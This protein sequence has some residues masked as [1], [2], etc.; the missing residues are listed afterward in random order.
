MFCRQANS[1]AGRGKKKEEVNPYE[2]EMP[3]EYAKQETAGDFEG[4]FATTVQ[5]GESVPLDPLVLIRECDPL[6][7]ITLK[8]H[9]TTGKAHHLCKIEDACDLLPFI[10]TLLKVK[11]FIT[12]SHDKYKKMMASALWK[13]GLTTEGVFKMDVLVGVLNGAL[14]K[15]QRPGGALG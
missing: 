6:G 13:L 5:I 1:A 10:H 4:A 2:E 7:L 8:T 12:V 11:T 15:S 3:P 14:V 9:L